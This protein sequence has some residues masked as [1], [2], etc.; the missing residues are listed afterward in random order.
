MSESKSCFISCGA[1]GADTE[2]LHQAAE[3]G[4]QVVTALPRDTDLEKYREK[5]KEI[6]AILGR[7]FPTNK[8]YVD[9]LLMRNIKAASMTHRIYA[10][11]YCDEYLS[12]A[13]GTAWACYTMMSRDDPSDELF[14]FDQSKDQWLSYD[15][16]TRRLKKIADKPPIPSGTWLGIGSRKLTYVGKNAIQ[17]LWR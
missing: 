14:F 4:H 2:W 13:G 9:R 16:G 11:G 5:T 15:H 12:I 8:P 17:S 3:H 6:A 1:E 7:G 10:I